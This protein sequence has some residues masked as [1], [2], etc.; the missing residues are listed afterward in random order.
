MNLWKGM[1][2]VSD[3]YNS[4]T[5]KHISDTSLNFR[6]LAALL[7]KVAGN[8]LE[9]SGAGKR[10]LREKQLAWVIVRREL[11]V[12]RWP[13]PGEAFTVT[14][15]A[16]KSRH[17]MFPR[18]FEIKSADPETNSE[19]LITVSCR[20]VIMDIETRLML[21]NDLLSKD[22]E[23]LD[24]RNKGLRPARGYSFPE[25]E[26]EKVLQVI[27]EYIDENG[28]MNNSYYLTWAEE[29]MVEAGF[30]PEQ[31]RPVYCWIEYAQ[32]LLQD[33]KA[34]LK[35]SMS[36]DMFFIQGFTQRTAEPVHVF[37]IVIK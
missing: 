17:G 25:P 31:G 27:P 15:W 36:D 3:I 19:S 30:R 13:E 7:E 37:S 35:W 28:H 23:C 11:K 1:R 33:E 16:G 5:E 20:W 8:H 6:E 12:S 34:T 22:M 29:L 18:W 24:E 26:N 21:Q 32:E 10:E 4:Y 9:K 14:T 2:Q